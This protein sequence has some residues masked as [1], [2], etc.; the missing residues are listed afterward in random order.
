MAIEFKEYSEEEIKQLEFGTMKPCE[1]CVNWIENICS[2]EAPCTSSG[3]KDKKDGY[4][5]AVKP[6]RASNYETLLKRVISSIMVW[7]MI[8]AV[9]GEWITEKQFAELKAIKERME[10][11][12]KK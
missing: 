4:Y 11:K 1:K 7:D 12:G 3:R 2:S 9:K 8:T 5:V 6:K 10:K